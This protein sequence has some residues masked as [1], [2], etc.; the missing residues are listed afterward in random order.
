MNRDILLLVAA[1]SILVAGLW[2]ASLFA[3]GSTAWLFGAL[4]TVHGLAGL[5]YGSWKLRNR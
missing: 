4:L 2:I 3:A 1:G 5:G